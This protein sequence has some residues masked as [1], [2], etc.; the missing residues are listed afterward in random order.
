MTCR[1]NRTTL[2]GK[3]YVPLN[4]TP[5]KN[6]RPARVLMYSHDTLG[7]GHLRRCR[8]I[9]HHLVESNSRL[10]VLILSGSPIIGSFEFRTR[11]DFVR[12][13]CPEETRKKKQQIWPEKCSFCTY[14]VSGTS[15]NIEKSTNGSICII[16]QIHFVPRRPF[17]TSRGD[18][19]FFLKYT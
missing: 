17:I 16:F 8:E 5:K 14:K 12:I 18:Q 7:L 3:C 6:S 10:S 15:S 11:V 4:R 19:K 1:M 13:P 2:W 9:A